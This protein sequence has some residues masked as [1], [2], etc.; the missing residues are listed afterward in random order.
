MNSCL[1]ALDI[2]NHYGSFF[3]TEDET[4]LVCRREADITY[5]RCLDDVELNV[6]LLW[7]C[8][9]GSYN[10]VFTPNPSSPYVVELECDKADQ[11]FSGILWCDL[12]RNMKLVKHCDIVAPCSEML[13]GRWY[14]ADS[15]DMLLVS[16]LLLFEVNTGICRERLVEYY[17]M[18]D[19][20]AFCKYIYELAK[21]LNSQ[22]GL[23]ERLQLHLKLLEKVLTWYCGRDSSS[24]D[25]LKDSLNDALY[26]ENVRI[27][28]GSA[29]PNIEFIQT[30]LNKALDRMFD[31]SVAYIN[32]RLVESVY[33]IARGVKDK[34]ASVWQESKE[35]F[36]SIHNSLRGICS[37]SLGN[38][39]P[40]ER[41]FGL[42]KNLI[43][44][45]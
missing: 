2:A 39:D 20:E 25:K 45:P 42:M 37:R 32:R 19:W 16:E 36:V 11:L 7:L 18:S 5:C 28:L 33:N 35:T 41:Y 29:A 23:L 31:Q 26:L 34:Y 3:Q 21:V 22:S 9:T 6:A 30:I 24:T 4:W 10:I 1:T 15:G 8:E 44:K 12:A 13:S 43:Q 17:F 40:I 38:S 14:L 27:N